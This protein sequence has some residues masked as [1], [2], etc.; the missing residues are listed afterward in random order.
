MP[1]SCPQ[2]LALA[3][4]TRSW[5]VCA[6]FHES[7]QCREEQEK[8]E[9]RAKLSLSWGCNKVTGGTTKCGC[10]AL[11][12]MGFVGNIPGISMCGAGVTR[13]RPPAAQCLGAVP[14]EPP[15]EQPSSGP[16]LRVQTPAN[17]QRRSSRPE[18]ACRFVAIVSPGRDAPWPCH[19]SR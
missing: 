2:P 13:G 14:A 5:E 6:N 18:S 17:R 7:I 16:A 4:G 11:E 10:H 3:P 12:L 1:K 8:R 9:A 15:S 19:W